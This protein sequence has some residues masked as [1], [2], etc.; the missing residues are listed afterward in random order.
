MR[1]E[2]GREMANVRNMLGTVVMDVLLSF[3]F[4]AI[5]YLIYFL[6]RLLQKTGIGFVRDGV[7]IERQKD[8][9]HHGPKPIQATY[10]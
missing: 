10:H 2:G 6:Y 7:N 4:A 5:L 8:I 9:Y 1:N 3:N